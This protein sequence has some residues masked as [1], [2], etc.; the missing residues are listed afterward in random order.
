MAES[1]SIKLKGVR[2]NN[3]KNIDIEIP[4]NKLVVITGLSG[5]GKSSLAFDTLFAEGQRRYVESLSSYARQFLGKMHKPEVDFIEGIPPTIAIR[6][7]VNTRNPRSTV[8]TSTEIYDYL[9]LFYAR[10]GKTFSPISGCEVKSHSTDD[11]IKKIMS[12]PENTKVLI[13]FPYTFNEKQEKSEQLSLINKQGYS[14]FVH[15]NELYKA[16][17]FKDTQKLGESINIVLDRINVKNEDSLL[18][19]IADSVQTAFF[20]GKG[21]C[22]VYEYGDSMTMHSFSNKYEADG[23]AF[24]PISVNLF[25]FNNP[26][27]AC[28]TCEGFGNILGIDEDLVVPNKGLSIYED[29]VCCWKG[30]IMSQWK[31]NFIYSSSKAKFPIHRPYYQLTEEEKDLLW[32]G[33]SKLKIYGI[34]DFFEHLEAEKYKIQNRVLISRYRGQRTCPDCHGKRLK[35]EAFYVKVNGKDIGELV[36]MPINDLYEY[37]S[38][39]KLNSYEEQVSARL[40]KEIRVRLEAMIEVGLGYLTL[41]RLSSTLSG[42]ESQR[43]NLAT[44]FG[45]G[46]VGSLYVLDEPSIGLHERDT[47]KLISILKKL[48]DKKNTV[49]V[50]EH[51][52]AIIKSADYIIDI[53]PL[54]G[55]QGGEVVFKG[56]ISELAKANTLTAKY[57]NGELKNPR[58]ECAL[59]WRN[60]IK[61]I[62]ARHNNL[63]NITAT[64]PLNAT[65]VVTGVSGS[66]KTSLVKGILYPA[67]CRH[68]GISTDRIGDFDKL[69]GDLNMITNI[70]YVDQNTISKS[71]RSNPA[72]YIKA[73]DEIRKLFAD[74]P[75]AKNRGLKTSHFSFNTEGGRCEVCQG[76]GEITVEMQFMSDIHLVCE[77]CNGKRYKDEVLEIKYRDKNIFDI[78]EMSIDEAVE[79]FKQGD[80]RTEKTIVDLLQ[81]YLNVGLGYLKM[82]QRTSDLSGGES[83]RV[84]LAS[85]LSHENAQPSIFIFDEP[86]TGLHFHDINKLLTSM[87]KIRSK[88]HTLIIIEHN[89]EII[90]SADWIIDL[91]PD[92][93]KNGGNIIFEGTPNDIIKCKDSLTGKFLKNFI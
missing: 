65:T 84:K 64:F 50:V 12:L 33:D 86:T 90:K 60:S 4:R 89:P 2:V 44:V 75:L 70:E 81:N 24:E 26:I 93:G 23:I 31:N 9:K 43:M 34:N 61:V 25:S 80:S 41:N 85:Y 8:G 42:G 21:E 77:A 14:R 27:G 68:L 53:G 28:P 57:I 92:G 18:G 69:S 87:Q 66:G 79:F 48:R 67:V 3:L 15:D 45:S 19:R 74:Q 46:L 39:I 20:E 1:E 5:S 73:F 29:A 35:K 91:G 59:K 30:E 7:K 62:G 32:R 11:V 72:M 78:L 55:E 51:D 16:E 49:V 10:V 83:Q 71:A 40:L 47:E 37:F 52:E 36:N 54:A 17:D 38:T 13:C 56:D 6:Q 76:D 88:G 63:K 22:C 58:N 82:G